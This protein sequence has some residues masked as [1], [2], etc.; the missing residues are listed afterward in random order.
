MKKSDE[1]RT[2]GMGET[3][4]A[5]E[6]RDYLSD[7]THTCDT[8][9]RSIIN[10]V[11]KHYSL[12]DYVPANSRDWDSRVRRIKEGIWKRRFTADFADAMAVL[13]WGGNHNSKALEA[14]EEDEPGFLAVIASRVAR[15]MLKDSQMFPFYGREVE[16][17]QGIDEKWLR[18]I[19]DAIQIYTETVDYY[20]KPELCGALRGLS[21]GLFG[22]ALKELPNVADRLCAIR[23]YCAYKKVE[24]DEGNAS[25]ESRLA[26]RR[27]REKS[28]EHRLGE[29]ADLMLSEGFCSSLLEDERPS[30]STISAIRNYPPKLFPLL[31]QLEYE[32]PYEF[33]EA[34][35]MQGAPDEM[36]QTK[37]AIEG[38]PEN[39][40]VLVW[41]QSRPLLQVR[42]EQEGLFDGNVYI[43]LENRCNE[44]LEASVS[45]VRA[46]VID[47]EGKRTAAADI[48]W[49]CDDTRIT[50]RAYGRDALFFRADERE[51]WQLSPTD[52]VQITAQVTARKTDGEERSWNRAS[53]AM[54][55]LTT[56]RRTGRGNFSDDSRES[57]DDYSSFI[58]AESEDNALTRDAWSGDSYVWCRSIERD[59]ANNMLRTNSYIFV[60]GIK[61]VGKTAFCKA[62]ARERRE[63]SHRIP[64]FE[65]VGH[66]WGASFDENIKKNV[67]PLVEDAIDEF[68]ER[69]GSKVEELKARFDVVKSAWSTN[70]T[71]V[72]ERNETYRSFA[73]FA[74]DTGFGV[75]VYIDEF[76]LLWGDNLEEDA[77]SV[78]GF[79]NAMDLFANQ[80]PRGR[81]INP[82]LP[83]QF[84]FCGCGNLV[85]LYSAR[86]GRPTASL[87]RG[88]T[89]LL[90]QL[91]RGNPTEVIRRM[92]GDYYGDESDH[93]IMGSVHFSNDAIDYLH[94]FT[95]GHA[96][97]IRRLARSLVEDTR[98]PRS[99]SSF[100]SRKKS[101]ITASD[102][103]WLLRWGE[104]GASRQGTP[105]GYMRE[106]LKEDL[107]DELGEQERLIA[108]A[109]ASLMS[110][111][112]C[113]G[114]QQGVRLSVIRNYCE[115]TSVIGTEFNVYLHMLHERD[116]VRASGNPRDSYYSFTSEMYRRYFELESRSGFETKPSYTE[117]EQECLTLKK[118]LS[119][120][121]EEIRRQSAILEHQANNPWVRI[122]NFNATIS[123]V[124]NGSATINFNEFIN[125]GYGVEGLSADYVQ[126][127]RE[128]VDKLKELAP[129]N[130][131]LSAT[132]NEARSEL[133]DAV[134]AQSTSTSFPKR[135][136]EVEQWFDA[137]VAVF[138]GIGF[139]WRDCPFLVSS[140]RSEYVLEPMDTTTANRLSADLL[141]I[142]HALMRSLL[143]YQTL[144]AAAKDGATVQDNDYAAA[145]TSIC[146]SFEGLWKGF[147][148]KA[149]RGNMTARYMF[150]INWPNFNLISGDYLSGEFVNSFN[151][152][153]IEAFLNTVEP[154][155]RLTKDQF[156]K[157][158]KGKYK[159]DCEVGLAMSGEREKLLIIL[160]TIR[161]KCGG[162]VGNLQILAEAADVKVEKL[163]EYMRLYSRFK[164]L[165]NVS[166][167]G[168]TNEAKRFSETSF[169]QLLSTLFFDYAAASA[170]KNN[171]LVLYNLGVGLFDSTIN[172]GL[173]LCRH[174]E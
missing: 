145:A 75:D 166:V 55:V 50:L 30:E 136:G 137:N 102:V 49:S 127:H 66:Q 76:Q 150:M 45:D 19:A 15:H 62:L 171:D 130:A 114:C 81:G 119:D 110:S 74:R 117:I 132:L 65:T 113:T 2:T 109:L 154:R 172:L 173:K 157:G 60:L 64:R 11:K 128:I 123:S 34:Y 131:L 108:S 26:T 54:K 16:T 88:R 158:K 42:F 85:S 100:T 87:F 168:T 25:G 159:L 83:I 77:N 59:D 73:A 28:I 84:I 143:V 138:D 69:Q 124:F 94:M 174:G 160:D 155:G 90:K 82:Y 169:K 21:N 68:I 97:S 86:G 126:R 99:G 93:P 106:F 3:D 8:L 156:E 80:L 95:A 142:C 91:S 33:D 20:S 53:L 151:L 162:Q 118:K 147:M 170:D 17:L 133:L 164:E 78:I 98:Y 14:L 115:S 63:R 27:A 92:L 1:Q 24:I 163:D 79:S 120:A 23:V 6:I 141:E 43:T 148:L 153:G 165:R 35:R 149:M 107:E 13:A 29:I 89:I 121:E 161:T 10:A 22:W 44:R 140:A 12:H 96:R 125:M 139:S 40:G 36:R 71:A 144:K 61:G 18:R 31:F 134:L 129:G 70:N 135:L 152:G 37:D 104:G 103:V 112:E 7:R 58:F 32:D 105:Y 39:P 5:V 51:K 101:V 47:A 9:L 56:D 48:K 111:Q 116:V 167:H 4:N 46:Y 57:V 38:T 67:F 146:R 122:D 52:R 72:D 41:L